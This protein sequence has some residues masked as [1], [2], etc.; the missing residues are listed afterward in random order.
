MDTR[1]LSRSPQTSFIINLQENPWASNCGTS[2]KPRQVCLYHVIFPFLH[3]G[4]YVSWRSL[5]YNV[6]KIWRIEHNLCLVLVKR[7]SKK[8]KKY[9]DLCRIYTIQRQGHLNVRCAYTYTSLAVYALIYDLWISDLLPLQNANF[10]SAVSIHDR[11]ASTLVNYNV[12]RN[13]YYKV[14]I[15]KVPG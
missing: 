1:H 6:A 3:N 2:R 9:Y 13:N 4:S 5:R 15:R 10:L 14:M 12:T 11:V 8:L 7:G